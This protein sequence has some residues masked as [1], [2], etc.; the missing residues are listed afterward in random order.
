M[1]RPGLPGKA[2]ES[3][4]TAA[5]VLDEGG[6]PAARDWQ[7]LPSLKIRNFVSTNSLADVK[8]PG[9]AWN[10]PDLR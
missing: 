5:E 6:N 10:A 7:P 2:R 8:R 3:Y 9:R 4:H 1:L